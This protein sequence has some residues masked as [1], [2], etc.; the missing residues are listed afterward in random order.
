M[1]DFFDGEYGFL[2][3]FYAHQVFGFRTVEHFYQAAKAT[4]RYDVKKIMLAETPREAKKIGRRIELRED[5][6][7]VKISVMQLALEE[8]FSG[9]L[10]TSL[11]FTLP[12]K[13]VEGNTW[14]DNFWG[15]CRCGKCSNISG[16]NILGK[17]LESVREKLYENELVKARMLPLVFPEIVC[18][19]NAL[20]HE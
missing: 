3:N 5:W 17:L 13:L 14:H 6:D 10:R 15:D 8:K 9:N 11:I 20:K 2:S 4:N 12:H 16:A 7:A 18:L 19:E 1:I